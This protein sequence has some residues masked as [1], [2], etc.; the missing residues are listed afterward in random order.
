M[1]ILQRSS[2]VRKSLPPT[3]FKYRIPFATGHTERKEDGRIEIQEVWGTRPRIGVGGLYL[4]HG[5]FVLPGGQRG[6]LYF[7]K[8]ATGAWAGHFDLS[9]GHSQWQGPANL[10]LQSVAVDNQRAEFTLLH[11]MAWQGRARML[12]SAS[13]KERALFTVLRQCVFRDR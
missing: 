5:K 12:S 6:K 9:T 13:G 1:D 8:T 11:G 7:Y 3:R 4:V 2:N 10:D